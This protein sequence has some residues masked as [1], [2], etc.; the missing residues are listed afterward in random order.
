MNKL[1]K[2]NKDTDK[3]VYKKVEC[4][5]DLLLKGQEV[6]QQELRLGFIGLAKQNSE[7]LDLNKE[8]NE[9][10]EMVISELDVIKKE[11]EDKAARRKA[12]SNRKRLP[13]RDPINSEIYNLLMKESEGPSYI[14]TR[15]RIAICLL[16]VTGIRISELLSLKVGTTGNF[17]KGRLGFNY[18]LKKDLLITKPF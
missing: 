1:E 11:R 18:R 6:N 9:Q 4:Q 3:L 16:T 12:W 7:L 8:L 13:K 14:A 2:I 5:L 17:I 10:L 15:T